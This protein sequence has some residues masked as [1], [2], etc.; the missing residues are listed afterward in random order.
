[1]SPGIKDVADT[2]VQCDLRSAQCTMAN[3]A[4][5]LF[6]SSGAKISFYVKALGRFFQVKKSLDVCKHILTYLTIKEGS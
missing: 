1:M 4:D 2:Q 6:R 5:L 3:G